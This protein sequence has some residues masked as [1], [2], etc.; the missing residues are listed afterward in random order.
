[1]GISVHKPSRWGSRREITTAGRLFVAQDSRLRFGFLNHVPG[2][3]INLERPIEVGANA[4]ILGPLAGPSRH[5]GNHCRARARSK[6]TRLGHKGSSACDAR[7][8]LAPTC[9]MLQHAPRG[10]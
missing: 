6:M 1:M 3:T 7:T 9:A 10:S 5:G 4:L 8:V 2:G